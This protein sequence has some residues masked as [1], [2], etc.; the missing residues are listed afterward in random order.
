MTSTL[1][2]SISIR[3]I[4]QAAVGIFILAAP[5]LFGKGIALAFMLQ[6][7]IV[8]IFAM[9]YNMLLGQTGMLSFGH[10]VYA[11]VGGYCAIHFLNRLGADG[12]GLGMI[13]LPLVGGIGGAVAGLILGY[14]STRRSGTTFAMITLGI[15]EMVVALA[16][17]LPGVSGGE[18]GITTNRMLSTAR[19]GINFGSDV[20]VYYFAWGW[21]ALSIALI[22]AYTRT[23]MGRLANAVRDNPERVSFIGFN[24]QK[25]RLSVMVLAGFFAGISGAVSVVNYELVT[26]ENLGI[27]QSGMV[28]VA[29]YLGGVGY[30]FGP[31]LGAFIYV[32]FLSLISSLSTAWLLYFGL[33]F[34]GT[35]L[36]A[37][38]GLWKIF[39]S[40]PRFTPTFVVNLC[41]ALL[42]IGSGVYAIEAIYAFRGSLDT[43]AVAANVPWM[44][45]VSR[46]SPLVVIAIAYGIT[47]VWMIR[48]DQAAVQTVPASRRGFFDE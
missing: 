22:Y 17:L 19:L 2:R 14:V 48:R 18:A 3:R 10:A 30:F 47:R 44:S 28:L 36:F 32:V 34:I 38:R 23:P 11:G 1:Q 8:S 20:Q 39:L 13:A 43:T 25:L 5:L 42:L 15:A 21:A 9:S 35:V 24:P 45:F 27:A 46:V 7:A 6:F 37:P 16:L 29:T 4:V 41:L 31:V 33:L 40:R 12:L 26:I